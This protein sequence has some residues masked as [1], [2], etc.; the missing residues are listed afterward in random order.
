MQLDKTEVKILE[1]LADG[2]IHDDC[3]NI[4]KKEQYYLACRSLFDKKLI[5]AAWYD[6]GR[7]DSVKIQTTGLGMLQEMNDKEHEKLTINNPYTKAELDVL[8]FAGR[9]K[10]EE[11]MPSGMFPYVYN[12]AIQSLESQGLVTHNDDYYVYLTDNGR[13]EWEVLPMYMNYELTELQVK[14]L[15]LL[16]VQSPNAKIPDIKKYEPFNLYSDNELYVEFAPLKENS[17]IIFFGDDGIRTEKIS[18]FMITP[19]GRVALREYKKKD[20]C[21][22]TVQTI[23]KEYLEENNKLKAKITELEKES[24]NDKFRIKNLEEEL[25]RVS[26]LNAQLKSAILAEEEPF[27]D[28]PKLATASQIVQIVLE[29]KIMLEKSE[30]EKENILSLITGLSPRSFHNYWNCEINNTN[31]WHKNKIL[32]QNRLEKL[33]EESKK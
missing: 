28:K 16:V 26:E 2:K 25:K 33:V 24:I 8:D 32:L 20:D 10:R 6:G 5:K 1:F 31:L 21:Q 19:R 29:N 13:K 22:Q 12:N 30:K 17:L 3:P 23:N 11:R 18:H 4:L 9:P 27:A 15:E 14:L 7:C